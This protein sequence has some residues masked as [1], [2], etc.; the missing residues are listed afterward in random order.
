MVVTRSRGVGSQRD[1]VNAQYSEYCVQ[2]CCI[3]TI[4][5]TKRL[6]LS[7]SNHKKEMIMM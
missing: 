5:L 7:Y 2:Q 6:D 4:R 3:V 1:A